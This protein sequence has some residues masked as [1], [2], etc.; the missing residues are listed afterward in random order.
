MSRFYIKGIEGPSNGRRVDRTIE[1]VSDEICA[2]YERA[3]SDGATI[4]AAHALT[5]HELPKVTDPL[6]D[7]SMGIGRSCLFLVVENLPAV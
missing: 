7:L 3:A 4:V 2:V 6:G 1:D 5:F